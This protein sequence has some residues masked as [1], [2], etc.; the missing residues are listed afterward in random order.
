MKP[1]HPLP[2]TRQGELKLRVRLLTSLPAPRP[3]RPEPVAR[4]APRTRLLLPL[5]L[6]MKE[7]RK[8]LMMPRSL[9]STSRLLKLL[10]TLPLLPE[11]RLRKRLRLQ[12][13]RRP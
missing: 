11:M 6:P 12:L 1:K 5:L 3:L 9:S 4:N 8:P 7:L 13:K 2:S 10:A